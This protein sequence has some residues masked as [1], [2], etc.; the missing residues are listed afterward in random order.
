MAQP[1]P[2][3]N[4]SQVKLGRLVIGSGVMCDANHPEHLQAKGEA[5][6]QCSAFKYLDPRPAL[7]VNR[8]KSNGYIFGQAVKQTNT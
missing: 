8:L 7:A 4:I 1:T 2:V 3:E 5:T 6:T